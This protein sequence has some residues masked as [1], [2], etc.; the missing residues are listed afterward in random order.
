MTL[1]ASFLI[2][3]VLFSLVSGRAEKS[4]ITGPMVTSAAG[5][6]VYF[7]LPEASTL[8]I[9]SPGVLV[10]AELTLAVALFSDATHTSLRQ[11]TRES[12]LPVRLLGIGMP[13]AILAATVRVK[14]QVFDVVN[15]HPESRSAACRQAS[16]RQIFE[17]TG[18]PDSL[19]RDEQALLPGDF[20]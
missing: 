14:G 8:E 3:A 19:V 2:L 13:L 5:L 11:V 4:V 10:V 17:N 1:L 7:A 16:I 15:A 9:T 18:Q 12:K 6:L 20:A